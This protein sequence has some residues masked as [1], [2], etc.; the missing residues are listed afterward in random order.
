MPIAGRETDRPEREGR[1]FDGLA[2]RP[3]REVP[4]AGQGLWNVVDWLNHGVCLTSMDGTICYVNPRF[5]EVHGYAVHELIGVKLS[6]LHAEQQRLRVTEILREVLSKG[7][8][9]LVEVLHRCRDGRE[10]PML[11]SVTR[12]DDVGGNPQWFALTGEDVT[13]RKRQEQALKESQEKYLKA[14]YASP[15]IMAIS[16]FNEGEF[17]EVNDEFLRSAGWTREQ[18][19]GRTSNELKIWTQ[20]G[21]R[22]K[23][24]SIVREQGSVRNIPLLMGT[25]S[26][27]IRDI[28]FSTEKVMIRGRLCLLSSAVDV[29]E[30]KRAEEAKEKLRDQLIQTQRMEALGL[31]AGGIA[32]DFNNLLTAILGHSGL[33]TRRTDV[34]KDVQR[35]AS[36][37]E[38][39]AERAAELTRQLLGFARR[40]KQQD[41]VVDLHNAVE[42]V[43]TLLD[44][45]IDK[46][47]VMTQRLLASSPFVKGD[48]SQLQQVILNL[49]VNAR[50]AMPTGGELSFETDVIEKADCQGSPEQPAI[51]A[52]RY[53]K[54]SVSDSGCGIS[55]EHLSRI[56][57]PFF[58]TKEPG[59]GTGM[60]LS[61]VYGIVQNHGG[62]V[63]VTSRLAHGSRFDLFLPLTDERPKD[64]E[65]P[66]P[67]A[68]SG[69]GRILVVDDEQIV[70]RV[71]SQLLRWL[72]YEVTLVNSG[73]EAIEV[74]KRDRSEI[75]AVILDLSMP[76][77]SG[78][79]C[80]RA[81]KEI[82][83]DVRVIVS[84]GY[85]TEPVA[86]D[87][88]AQGARGF[89]GKPYSLN[90]LSKVLARVLDRTGQTR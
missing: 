72:D 26:G 11:M 41:V 30:L 28:L 66:L 13:E 63:E 87:A 70:L 19:V 22:E 18:M 25:R 65:E 49:A 56:F 32:H 89:I 7:H 34:S 47:I 85:A 71:A 43:F 45:T 81:L 15:I 74:Y 57:E 86:R 37:I 61:M 69:A 79:E 29:T 8:V 59:K 75:S 52:G 77:M 20:S 14:F 76:E 21:H 2:T 55:P 16:S 23:W 82:N 10:F 68:A 44:R 17:L 1:P 9:T 31:L 67:V 38:T 78:S 39:A 62:H 64:R 36:A 27:E 84:T 80:F 3:T 90:E 42:E 6:I 60:G 51:G 12:V 46:K 48:P 73:R 50:D 88:F 58:T 33:L 4:K 54:L 83:P 53:L 24:L 35:E 5:A 40:G